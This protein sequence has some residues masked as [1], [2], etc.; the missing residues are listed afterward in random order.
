MKTFYSIVKI[1]NH[2]D[3]YD[4]YF[5]ET[6]WYSDLTMEEINDLLNPLEKSADLFIRLI[7]TRETDNG[8][9]YYWNL[10]VDGFPMYVG[11]PLEF[12]DAVID[13]LLYRR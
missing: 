13:A 11:I 1:G 4:L 7:E 6:L 2:D 9:D 8:I 10:I 3:T 12:A 5:G